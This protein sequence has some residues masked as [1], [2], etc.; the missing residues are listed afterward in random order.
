ML[1]CLCQQNQSR[2]NVQHG[3]ILSPTHS[4]T[5]SNSNRCSHPRNTRPNSDPTQ[6]IP[7]HTICPG[8]PQ[9]PQG[10]PSHRQHFSNSSTAKPSWTTKGG[11]TQN[12]FTSE[13]VQILLSYLR[14]Q[15]PGTNG[16]WHKPCQ[17]SHHQTNHPKWAKAI[18][19]PDTGASM[20]YQHLIESPKYKKAWT[21]SFSSEL[22][23]LAQGIADREKGTNRT[24]FIPYN[25]VPLDQRK[26]VT[27]GH[28][29]VDYRSQKREPN[30]TRLTV[31]GL[32]SRCEYFHS[33]HN[34]GQTRNQQHQIHTTGEVHVWRHKKFYLGTPMA[35]Y[36]YM[37]LPIKL[38]LDEIIEAY[39]LRS[40]IHKDHIYM[41]ISRGMYGLPQAGILANQLLTT[42]LEPHG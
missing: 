10:H 35:R 32:S 23:R 37:R 28:I 5:I 17:R 41:E 1:S 22:G 34:H 27:Y 18:N 21:K 39:N 13:N 6:P 2:T 16:P 36:E 26:D 40:M 8:R 25:K 12:C 42:R 20:E 31:G 9:S 4:S 24:F 19:H 11:Q 29:C 14:L 30:W 7:I 15:L 3:E 33:R 38:I